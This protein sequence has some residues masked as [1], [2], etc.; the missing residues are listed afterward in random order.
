MLWE[1]P[2]KTLPEVHI[3]CLSYQIP[4]SIFFFL[5][6]PSGDLFIFV[7]NLVKGIGLV[8]LE[9]FVHR[10]GL[11]EA[12]LGQAATTLSMLPWWMA[13]IHREERRVQP[14][15]LIQFW[16]SGLGL[17][18]REG[19]SSNY[20]GE[21][22]NMTIYP[23]ETRLSWN[24][25]CGSW[26][27]SIRWQNP[28]VTADVVWIQPGKLHMKFPVIHHWAPDAKTPLHFMILMMNN[29]WLTETLKGWGK[30]YEIHVSLFPDALSRHLNEMFSSLIQKI[31]RMDYPYH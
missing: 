24:S 16:A 27:M 6:L 13:T 3:K 5:C 21:F 29:S 31:C 23:L 22:S 18:D 28:V 4:S 11:V 2:H 17:S 19:E 1:E 15:G 9:T 10:V 25:F 8:P 30:V 26:H 12:V 20:S 14:P 7:S